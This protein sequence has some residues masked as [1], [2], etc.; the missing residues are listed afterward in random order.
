MR[1]RKLSTTGLEVSCGGLG[2]HHIGRPTDE[3][4]SVRLIRTVIDSGI[5]FL[6]DCWDYHDGL[7]QLRMG[8]ALQDG[9]R[10][11]VVLMTKNDGRTA[12]EAKK[13]LDQSL[14][15]LRTD[16]IYNPN[17]IRIAG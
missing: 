17:V 1:F 6:D 13:Q 15:R 12:A 10:N 5:N 11:K 8:K 16:T 9:N 14:L 2:G 3:A 7:S 4:E